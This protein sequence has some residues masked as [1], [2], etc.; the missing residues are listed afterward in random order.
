L[1]S[2]VPVRGADMR[3]HNDTA[4]RRSRRYRHYPRL[5]QYDRRRPHRGR[6]TAL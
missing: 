3:L 2:A 5:S 4:A 1:R 6:W